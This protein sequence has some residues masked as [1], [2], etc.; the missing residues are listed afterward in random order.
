M[1]C[2]PVTAGNLPRFRELCA[3]ERLFGSRSL[4]AHIAGTARSFLLEGFAPA[5]LSLAEN[6]L[7]VVSPGIADLG[8]LEPFIAEYTEIAEVHST[9]AL[10]VRLQEKLGGDLESSFFMHCIAPIFPEEDSGIRI[11]PDPA[12]EIVFGI[13]QGSHSYYQE[14]LQFAPWSAELKR[15]QELGLT[16]L[17]ALEAEGR[18]VGTGRILSQDDVAGAIGGVAVL[19]AYRNRGYGRQ[20]SAFLTRRVLE[21]GKTPVLISGY[22][23]VAA[24]YRSIGYQETGRWGEL[25]FNRC[26]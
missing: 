26:R 3:G 16:E 9:L 22:D 23:E 11:L 17:Y 14:H 10:C 25:Y 5:A 1:S 20:M 18:L 13:L 7:T 15:W 12:P 19:P 2:L 21:L 4:C 8:P 6:V 24:L